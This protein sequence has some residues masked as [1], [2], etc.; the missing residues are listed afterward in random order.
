[1]E[2]SL[3]KPICIGCNMLYRG[4][5][6]RGPSPRQMDRAMRLKMLDRIRGPTR[7]SG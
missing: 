3:V 4:R 2:G 6:A 7:G 5:D 1:M